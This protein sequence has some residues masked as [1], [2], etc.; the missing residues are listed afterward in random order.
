MTQ[1]D[2]MRRKLIETINE[3]PEDKL[4]AVD[5]LI[6]KISLNQVIPIDFIY[7]QAKT[8]YNKTLQKLAE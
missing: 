1:V 7:S 3:L 2:E 5:D 6:K 8:N 4:I